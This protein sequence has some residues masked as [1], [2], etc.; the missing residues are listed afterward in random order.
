MPKA[1]ELPIRND[2]DAAEVLAKDAARAV[3]ELEHMGVPFNRTQEGKI[4]TLK[5]KIDELSDAMT[6]VWPLAISSQG[7]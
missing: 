2:Q 5:Q 4:A 7:D 6:Q 1:K 3:Y